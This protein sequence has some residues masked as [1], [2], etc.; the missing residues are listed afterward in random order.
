M[1]VPQNTIRFSLKILWEW[2]LAN[3]IGSVIGGIILFFIAFISTGGFGSPTMEPSQVSDLKLF[4]R[5]LLIGGVFGL[6]LG[7]CEAFAIMAYLKNASAWILA[8]AAGFAI[9]IASESVFPTLSWALTGIL[10]GTFQWMVLRKQVQN[11]LLWVVVNFGLG[12]II[13]LLGGWY[14]GVIV[15]LILAIGSIFTGITL[16]W[17]ITNQK[18]I[19]GT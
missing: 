1:N 9:G 7:I 17:L 14:W 16:A 5:G 2:I 15:F 6:I 3:L 8:T 13:E 18:R 12:L 11:S 19:E 10:V 4:I